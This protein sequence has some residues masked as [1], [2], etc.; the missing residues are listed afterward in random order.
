MKKNYSINM[1]AERVYK[2]K[3]FSKMTKIVFLL[4]I[5]ALSITYLFLY[6]IY[7]GASFTISLD[8]N[9]ANQK[10]LYLS[11]DGKKEHK[12][13]E[14]SVKTLDY[15]DN[16]SIDWLPK[17]IDT[18]IGGSHNGPNYIA[19]TF[20]VI[21][22]GVDAINYWYNVDIDDSIRN[23][24]SAIRIMIYQNHVPTIYAKKNAITKK[25]EFGTKK[26]YSNEKVLLEK[27][28]QLKAKEKD[29][30]TLVIWIEGDDPD[31]INDLLG[32]EIKMNMYFTEEH[33][34]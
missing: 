34:K 5:G 3:L 24:D 20:Y 23:V 13:I 33:V 7:G 32:G 22:T 16:I 10:S 28:E 4:L 18:K 12:K 27:R 17:D 26:F 2:R 25:E 11:E 9:M 21:N 30:Y 31:C 1:T 19:Y 6:I 8:K 29:C 14:L 15:M